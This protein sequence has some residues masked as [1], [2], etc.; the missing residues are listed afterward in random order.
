MFLFTNIKGYDSL[1]VTNIFHVNRRAFRKLN[2]LGK[3]SDNKEPE[4]K[5]QFIDFPKHRYDWNNENLGYLFLKKK[6]SL[7]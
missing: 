3:I 7:V 1:N 4:S 5:L 2:H 6:K